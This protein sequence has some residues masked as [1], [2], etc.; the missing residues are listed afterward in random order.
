M[1]PTHKILKLDLEGRATQEGNTF[2]K[3]LRSLKNFFLERTQKLTTGKDE[4]EQRQ[5]NKQETA[6]LKESI[7]KEC[8]DANVKLQILAQARDTNAYLKIWSK[9][10]ERGWLHFAANSKVYDTSYTGRG[11]VKLII[12][13]PHSEAKKRAY[14]RG[15]EARADITAVRQARRCEQM[16]FRIAL[17]KRTETDEEKR[18]DMQSSAT[19]F[20]RSSKST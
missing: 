16:A 9:N 19:R 6:G 15:E 10:V 13:K 12:K 8:E 4:K 3:K 1:I 17:A 5:I 11:Q 2:A 14:T 20:W 7:R 18:R